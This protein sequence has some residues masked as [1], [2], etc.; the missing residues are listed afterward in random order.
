[1]NR[2]AKMSRDITLKILDE[3][4]E[5]FGL[6]RNNGSSTINLVG[7]IPDV[8]QTRS[9]HIN[10]S[11]VGAVP[12]LANAVA[13]TQIFEARSGDTQS[14]EVDL[15][16][17]DN[18]LDPNIGMTPTINGQVQSPYLRSWLLVLIMHS[19]EI[20]LDLIAGNPFLGGIYKTVDGRH[21]VPSAVYVDLVYQWCTFLQ[22]APNHADAAAAILKWRSHGERHDLVEAEAC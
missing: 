6:D 12:S 3:I 5:D 1:M 8:Q 9:E 10:M 22:C 4:L 17:S 16:R 11:L 20:T 21:V 2:E 18:Y 15:Q 7:S 19:Q 13:A 14:I